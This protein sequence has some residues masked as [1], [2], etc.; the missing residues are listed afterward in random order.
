M[1]DFS[2]FK[3]G[4]V[5]AVGWSDASVSKGVRINRPIPNKTLD[6]PQFDVGFFAGIFKGLSS[7]RSYVVL[8]NEITD[9]AIGKWV[10]IPCSIIDKVY[11]IG[12]CPD[13]LLDIITNIPEKVVKKVMRSIKYGLKFRHDSIRLR[14]IEEG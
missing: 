12:N 8:V 9:Y 2:K 5:L 6:T 10:T 13:D 11:F 14:S 3:K 1:I 4:D 7:K